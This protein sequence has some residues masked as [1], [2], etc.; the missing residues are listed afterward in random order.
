[1]GSKTDVRKFP[2]E[3]G[4]GGG[5]KKGKMKETKKT[6]GEGGV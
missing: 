3:G 4:E 2:G 1:V 6:E 5:E